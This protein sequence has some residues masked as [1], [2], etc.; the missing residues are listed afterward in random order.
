MRTWLREAAVI[1]V[2]GTVLAGPLAALALALA[3]AGWRD[4]RVTWAMLAACL[5]LVA[6]LRR[7]RWRRP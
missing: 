6:V 4:A 1:A 3:P 5:V 7:R 2:A